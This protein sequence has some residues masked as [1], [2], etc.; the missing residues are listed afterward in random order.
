[1]YK[2]PAFCVLKSRDAFAPSPVLKDVQCHGRLDAVLFELTLRQTYCNESDQVL[3]VIYTFPLPDQAVVLGFAS[4]L[5]G[6]RH[7]GQVVAKHRAER[8][9]EE[10][11]A[12]GDMPVMLEALPDGLHTANIGNL[13]AGDRVV[14]EVRFAQLLAFD[15]GRLRVTVPTTIAPRYGSAERSG[16]QPQQVPQASLDAEYP[17]TL[18][19][20]VGNALAHATVDC[21]THRFATGVTAD[22]E[23]RL[24][25]LPGAWLDRDVVFT[26]TPQEPRASLLVHANNHFDTSAPFTMM[27]ALQ[28]A[29]GRVKER[30]ALKLLVDCSGSMAGDS[31][32]SARA[33]LHG[34]VGG[35]SRG[36]HLS[37][38]RFGT[39]VQHLLTLPD[40][41]PSALRRLHH[42]I[43]GI[44][45]DLGGTEM[46]NAF[47]E[48]FALPSGSDDTGADIL[49]ITD[50]EIWQADEL[51]DTARCSGHRVFAIGVGSA[52]AEGVLRS[53]AEATGGACEFATP[54]EVLEAAA[55]RMLSRIRQFSVTNVRLDWGSTPVWTSGP[56]SS[57]FG[58]D[59]VIAFAGFTCPP[60]TSSIRLLAEDARGAVELAKVQTDASCAGDRLPRIA[61]AHRL[62]N[63]AEDEALAIQYQLMSR[64]T[65][66]IVVHRRAE[67]DKA[68]E[69]AELHRVSS[70]LAAGWGATSRVSEM[71]NLPDNFLQVM[72]S[73]VRPDIVGSQ[74][75]FSRTLS[76]SRPPATI[77]L[78]ARTVAEFL[79][80]GGQIHE[81]AMH[82]E[83]L[84]LHSEAQQALDDAVRLGLNV[85]QVWLLFA[86]W[87]NTR[88]DGLADG[89][90]AIT[91]QP[92]LSAIDPGVRAQVLR[93]Y[94]QRLGAYPI[95][96]WTL[97]RAQRLRRSL[98]RLVPL[99]SE[100]Q[101]T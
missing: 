39:T 34:V 96:G 36:D 11:L 93:V 17:V 23:K 35:L 18:S 87:A 38:S 2:E 92:H 41:S 95:D 32:A 4:E 13:K 9:Y 30:I 31:I 6:E 33:A 78:M 97:S 29:A 73:P 90:L 100:K 54:G 61:A 101:R 27:A 3:E 51:I 46:L 77:E 21:P 98:G 7:E 84:S 99:G 64:Q 85:E 19:L 56:A 24:D 47:R 28:P 53:L 68:S 74:I 59:T 60:P 94:E 12:E 80:E 63:A 20:T 44:N 83:G 26:V 43:D 42:Q 15:Q 57:V 76:Q 79:A 52:P 71:V 62:C 55:Q 5:N 25:L 8:L 66:C 89:D 10:S 48:V 67:A 75:H 82:C 16:L 69:Q 65:N 45:A 50:G 1:M 88:R 40:L 49:L 58:G 22:G 81:L 72:Y 70:M 91:L 37:L 86:H 14:L